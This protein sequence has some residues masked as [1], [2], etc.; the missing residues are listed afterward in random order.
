M[1]VERGADH[2]DDLEVWV[3]SAGDASKHGE[4]ERT[5]KAN[6]RSALGIGCTVKILGPG[7]IARS[8]GKAVR[9]IDNRRI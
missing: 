9:V 6:L 5:L 3:E 4:L 1:V 8:E 7:E 2:M